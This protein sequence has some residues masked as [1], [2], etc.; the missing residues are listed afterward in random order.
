MAYSY[1]PWP[2]WAYGPKGE[3]EIFEREED[4]PKGWTHHGKAKGGDKSADLSD[5]LNRPVCSEEA[6]VEA[7]KPV[8]AE[9]KEEVAQLRAHYKK[10]TGK[11]AFNGWSADQ[12][13]A[14]LDEFEAK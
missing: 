12:I 10:V 6:L 3:S 14:K 8:A 5:P 13:R 9:G 4:V 2:C 11:T 1:Q 7:A